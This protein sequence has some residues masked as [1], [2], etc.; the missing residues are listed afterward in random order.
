MHF[1]MVSVQD[2]PTTR[3]LQEPPVVAQ[4]QTLFT[5]LP[6]AELL[7]ALE[8]RTRRGPKGHPVEMLW[9]CF[10]AKHALGLKSTAGLIRTLHNNPFIAG[11]CGIDSPDR[12]PHEATFSRFFAKLASA[13][14]LHLV[15]NVSRRIV[16]EHYS[17]LPA[18]GQRVALDSTTL[19]AWSNGGKTVKSDQDAGWSIK[20]G[21]HGPKEFTWGFKLHLVVDCE[22]EMPI[23]AHVS[24]GNAHD[25]V[26]ASNTLVQ[27]RESY[28]R[29]HPRYLMADAGYSSKNFLHLVHRQ[30]RATPV[31]QFHPSH[32]RL[33]EKWGALLA[34]PE[35][36]ALAKQRQAVERCFSRLKGQRSLNH[37]TTRGLR[38][39]TLHSYLAL[40]AMQ[41]AF[42]DKDI[43]GTL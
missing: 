2:T 35:G 8:G 12:V 41:S 26:R 32:R 21:T 42:L 9:R 36:R 5:K 30:Y 31:V 39:V 40:I 19:K 18:F 16:Q 23:G 33:K 24:A 3:L 6:D 38:K 29:F 28:P 15:K 27:A 14:F 37:I 1:Q 34:T 4:L 43:L 11:A 7:S 20:K 13:K 22:S 17:S 25:V 10:I